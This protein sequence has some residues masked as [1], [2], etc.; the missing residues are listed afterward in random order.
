MSRNNFLT[1]RSCIINLSDVLTLARLAASQS[2]IFQQNRYPP[3]LGLH[4]ITLH[5]PLLTPAVIPIRMKKLT[6]LFKMTY[7]FETRF[8]AC[9]WG[10]IKYF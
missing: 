1:T 3:R 5:I 8:G 9:C 6:S 10:N 4:G 7:S 2:I